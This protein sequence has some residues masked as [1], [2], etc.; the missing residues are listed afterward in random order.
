MILNL[1][2]SWAFAGTIAVKAPSAS[3]HEFF[4]YTQNNEAQKVSTHFLKCGKT[5]HLEQNLKEAQYH[6]LNSSLDKSMNMFK[7][8]AENK[9][10]CDWKDEER[11][12]VAFALFR[13]A[14]LSSSEM[15][16][17]QHLT[18]ALNFDDSIAPDESIFPPPIVT[19]YK[20]LKRQLT[21][22]SFTLP[23][24]AKN[25]SYVLRNG[26]FIS[27]SQPVL[28]VYS[29]RA[30]YTFISDAYKPETLVV[31]A[32]DLSSRSLEPHPWVQGDCKNPRLS[33]E[34]TD[35]QQE[36]KVFFSTDCI[37][38]L[39]GSSQSPLASNNYDSLRVP[40]STLSQSMPAAEK[41]SWLR[42]NYVWVGA[43]VVSSLLIAHQIQ[44]NNEP[45]RVVVPTN[46]VGQQ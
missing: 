9:W 35:T 2:I 33:D 5:I 17:I 15:D 41:K 37:A 40:P 3:S 11:R 19:L 27:L 45:Q 21:K 1:L 26:R 30:R 4:I 31:T 24:F 28:E 43:A 46:T 44:K 22:K 6:F 16:Q 12:V 14:Q 36:V 20:K 29:L 13:L 8:I 10:S 32:E 42:R 38:T 39:G 23:S 25:Y 7:A 34:L 18:D